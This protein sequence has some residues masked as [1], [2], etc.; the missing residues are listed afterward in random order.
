MTNTPEKLI[1]K[2]QN[3]TKEYILER[4]KQYRC[5]LNGEISKKRFKRKVF[6][7]G[8]L[9]SNNR[10]YCKLLSWGVVK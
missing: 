3:N 7:L 6:I 2:I 9:L 4:E 1:N 5:Y 10:H 8:K